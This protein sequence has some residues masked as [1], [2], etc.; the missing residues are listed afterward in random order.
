MKQA[1]MIEESYYP[2]DDARTLTRAQEIL[3]DPKRKKAALGELK[4]QADA[5][6]EALSRTQA[7]ADTKKSLDSVFKRNK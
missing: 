1:K 5:A 6:A 7:I 2:D 4:K 3:K